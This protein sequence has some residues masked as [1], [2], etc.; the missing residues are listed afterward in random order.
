MANE[1]AYLDT[2]ILVNWSIY[3]RKRKQW[4]KFREGDKARQSMELFQDVKNKRY[5][6]TFV[7]SEWA[8]AELHQSA[9]D[10]RIAV[11]MIRDLRN[12]RFFQTQKLK[13]PLSEEEK[14]EI[15]LALNT[16]VLQL[17]KHRVGISTVS[18]DFG[19]ISWFSVRYGVEAPDALPLFTALSLNSK[20][21]LTVDEPLKNAGVK[22]SEVLFPS[23]F[24]NLPI[25][26]RD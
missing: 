22:D 11:R 21:F 14:K 10:Y 15:V 6:T 7:T 25:H 19:R 20:Y 8:I 24:R 23:T 13:Y 12:P 9:I 5:A 18:P 3:Y 1:L 2:N 16:F 26:S 4:L 17:K